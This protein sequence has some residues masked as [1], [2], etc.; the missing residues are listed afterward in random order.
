MDSH[1]YF[2][3]FLIKSTVLDRL[4]RW[5]YLLAVVLLLYRGPALGPLKIADIALIAALGLFILSNYDAIS[6]NK[7]FLVLFSGFFT[8]IWF[9][10][11]VSPFGFSPGTI[12]DFLRY[13]IG[14]G[15]A[16]VTFHFVTNY[17]DGFERLQ[18]TFSLAAISSSILGLLAVGTFFLGVRWVWV[19][20]LL[21]SPGVPRATP[22]FY[23]PNHYASVLTIAYVLSYNYVF[24]YLRGDYNSIVWLGVPVVLAVGIVAA[25]SRTGLGVLM[26]TTVMLVGW[27]LV[28]SIARRQTEIIVAVVVGLVA[29]SSV[30]A[31]KNN[32]LSII[33]EGGFLRRISISRAFADRVHLW[34]VAFRVWSNHPLL[35]IGPDNYIRFLKTVADSW[36]LEKIKNPH[37]T[38]FTL[39]AQTGILGF[40]AFLL[41]YVRAT[42]RGIRTLRN[43]SHN[44]ALLGI[45]LLVAMAAWGV[46]LDIITSRRLW[47]A[48]GLS[49]GL[50][51]IVGG[52]E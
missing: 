40:G 38:Y 19:V 8:V 29:V 21:Y 12:R 15:F 51:Q 41:I 45:T 14:F 26:I 52:E 11:V 35:G 43:D 32:I 7:N 16:L 3:F 33:F 20:S 37:N 44:Y 13:L 22:F 50:F 24:G 5:T 31:L 9:S 46:F 10:I 27:S 39:L 18:Y 28:P 23:D 17:T 1:V 6:T 30:I 48:L 42:L 49:L 34:S 2:R 36:G 25:G 4:S 47:F